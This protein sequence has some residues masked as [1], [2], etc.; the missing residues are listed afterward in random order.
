MSDQDLLA[1]MERTLTLLDDDRERII[2][3]LY[4]ATG[5][6]GSTHEQFRPVIE[7]LS[8]ALYA[9]RSAAVKKANGEELTRP[10]RKSLRQA[11]KVTAA[12]EALL[13]LGNVSS[14]ASP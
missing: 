9:S 11:E 1:R 10:E 13:A 6:F 5:N 14:G 2:D 12:C 3:G 4:D 8:D 7:T